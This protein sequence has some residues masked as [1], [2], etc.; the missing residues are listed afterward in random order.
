[1]KLLHKFWLL[2]FLLNGI[3]INAQSCF[4]YDNFNVESIGPNALTVTT[5]TINVTDDLIIEDV[6]VNVSATHSWIGDMSIRLRSPLGSEIILHNELCEDFGDYGSP[7]YDDSATA[8]PTD[9]IL[10][11]AGSLIPF[12]PLTFFDSEN[13]FGDWELVIIDNADGDGGSLLSW[14]LTLCGEA[15]TLNLNNFDL[16]ENLIVVKEQKNIFNIILSNSVNY[17]FES[18]IIKVFD[19]AGRKIHQDI[20][21]Q[22]ND[23]N[24]F[25]Y[26]LEAEFFSPG[27][28]FVNIVAN[29]TN[30]I[31]PSGQSSILKLI[32]E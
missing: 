31:T 7:T 8:S 6:R 19:F 11:Y 16:K 5:S 18:C 32:V 21:N 24:Q 27:V 4:N 13:S 1:M 30:T 26:R 15:S 10:P 29:R 17:Q 22:R 28:Y 14:T 3:I 12:Q 23:K 25:I 9:C 20:M 2:L